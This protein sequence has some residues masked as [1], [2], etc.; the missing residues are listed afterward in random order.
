MWGTQGSKSGAGR[1]CSAGKHF[2]QQ[3]GVCTCARKRVCAAGKR[4][5]QEGVLLETWVCFPSAH[6][7]RL[8]EILPYPGWFSPCYY[9]YIFQRG[10]SASVF[11]TERSESFK[12]WQVQGEHHRGETALADHK[13]L[14]RGRSVGVFSLGAVLRGSLQISMIAERRWE[15]DFFSRLW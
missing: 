12:K 15:Q 9:G 4:Q 13:P 7:R 2:F 5:G 3:D 8:Q 6:V 11:Y 10:T 1:G 14:I